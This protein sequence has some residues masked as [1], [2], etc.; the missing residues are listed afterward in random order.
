M[1]VIAMGVASKVRSRMAVNAE[2]RVVLGGRRDDHPVVD[3]AASGAGRLHAAVVGGQKMSMCG[4]WEHVS[5]AS[6][7]RSPSA[8]FC[9]PV[10]NLQDDAVGVVGRQSR[11]RG[12]VS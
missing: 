3:H 11:W 2:R 6:R 12:T 7:S 9:V 5:A 1:N 4:G 10:F 8:E